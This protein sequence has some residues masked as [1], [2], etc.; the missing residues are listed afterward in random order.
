MSNRP[1]DGPG[2]YGHHLEGRGMTMSWLATQSN[3]AEYRISCDRLSVT[4]QEYRFF[5]TLE[6][7]ANGGLGECHPDER[8]P[9]R[10]RVRG[11]GEPG[12]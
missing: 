10:E 3:G 7:N 1:G 12:S 4:V 5:G 2:G 11:S 8:T 6:L 9:L